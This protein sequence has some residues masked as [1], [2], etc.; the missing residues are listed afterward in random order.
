MRLSKRTALL[1]FVGCITG[2][3]VFIPLLHADP[4]ADADRTQTIG[5]PISLLVQPAAITLA[6]SRSMQQVLVTGRFGDGTE[7]DLTRFC[8]W[9]SQPAGIIKV[10]AGG[11]VLPL[12]DGTVTLEI[13]AGGQTG[14]L[15]VVI[16]DFAKAEPVSFRRQMMPALSISGCNAGSCHGIPSG[17]NGF[18]LSLWGH[19]PAFDYV[20]LTRDQLGRRTNRAHPEAS[21]I[22]QKALGRVSHEGGRRFAADSLAAQIFRDWQAEGL[23]DDS[24]ELPR[25]TGIEVTTVSRVLHHP[26]RY[27]QL[28]VQ[29]RFADGSTRDVTRLTVYSS[30]D[31]AIARVSQTGLVEFRQS[32]EVAIL[33]RYMD[34][35]K[36]VRLMHLRSPEGFVWPNP[37]EKNYIDHHVFAKLK[38]LS[39]TPAEL[40]TDADF[41]RRV[42]LDVC[43]ILPTAGE[44]R[45]FLASSDTDKRAKLIDSLL[46]RPEYA[47]FWTL[48]WADVLRVNR[49]FIQPKGAAVYHAW[50]WNAVQNNTPF[51]EVVRALLT[52]QGHSYKEAPANYYCV[53]REPKNAEDLLQHD[54]VETTS[55]LFLGIR[56]RC[57]RCHNHPFER[58]TQDDYYGLAAFFA[59][60][61]QLREGKDPGVGN[62][63]HR[64]VTISLDLKAK[65]LVQPRSGK[66]ALPKFLGGPMAIIPEGKDRRAL[67]ADW[68]TRS[69]NPYFARSVVN[70]LWFH[71]NGRGIV[72]P[73]DDFRDSNPSANDALLDALAQ[74]FVASKYNVKHVLR[75][76][77]QSRTYQLSARSNAL[78]RHDGKYFSHVI[79]RPLTAEQLFDA[80]CTVTGV[81]EP[82]EGVPLG[83]RAMQLPDGEV[84]ASKGRYL[85]YDRHPFMK[86]FG[87]PDRELPCECA[88]ESEF[89]MVQA[90]E[91]LN[92]PTITAKLQEPNNRIGKLLA[93]KTGA[94]RTD[95]EILDELYLTTLCRLPSQAT[96]K[97]FLAYVA[98]AEDRRRAWEDVLWTILRSKEFIY[99][100]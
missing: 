79:A 74:D 9:T 14:K 18:R 28:A 51:D 96:S 17:R 98:R 97:A 100:H 69:D 75:V 90:M 57:A 12:R 48:K 94:P 13:R 77:L 33:C 11:M 95:A 66:V 73:V 41:I 71:L 24:P 8:E 86:V 47:D 53:V 84:F 36:S 91:M 56:I 30:S 88:R 29:A 31:P 21:L 63:E 7:R 78:N 16:R 10:Q 59:Q 27:Q 76:I 61:K 93:N 20:Q 42:Y 5:Q 26:S 46:E 64:P 25:S 83:T 60:V 2:L 89:T 85:N 80:V 70:R 54:L 19:D 6:G 72:D 39:I 92:G 58:W 37:P 52:S 65:E 40:C 34:Q 67:L 1:T 81:P 55:Q 15:T 50:L 43:G 99:R 87:Q 23:Q 62:P 82:F 4:P 45:S 38:L 68:L 32:D 3:A 44:T 22:L 35:V 49:K